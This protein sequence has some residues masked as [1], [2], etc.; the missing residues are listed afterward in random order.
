MK[1]L[2]ETAKL[3][4]GCVIRSGGTVAFSLHKELPGSIGL[5]AVPSVD[6][7][8]ANPISTVKLG[9]A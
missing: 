8:L 4:K 2:H 9:L 7:I 5:F 6:E 3:H 1:L